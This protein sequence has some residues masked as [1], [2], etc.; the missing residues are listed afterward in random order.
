M[1]NRLISND[2]HKPTAA[3]TAV[4]RWKKFFAAGAV[5]VVIP[6][7]GGVSAPAFGDDMEYSATAGQSLALE[8]EA[9]NS[10]EETDKLLAGLD[11]QSLLNS[12]AV[13]EVENATSWKLDSGEYFIRVPLGGDV[14]KVSA[15]GVVVAPNG[16]VTSAA[17]VIA[18]QSS[19]DSGRIAAWNNGEKV[20]DR[21][22]FDHEVA[23]SE[24]AGFWGTLNK[25][26]SSAGVAG[27]VVAGLS[28]ACGAA[29]VGTA[30][31]GCVVCL[32]AASGIGAGTVSFCVNKALR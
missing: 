1:T 5:G 7:A 19:E 26:L 15:L 16:K 18:Q 4:T 6:F 31:A 9:E 27:W 3:K 20:A 30:G 32:T 22:V 29:C 14:D 2:H 8:L 10:S 28:V 24:K 17:E 11:V 12:E 13:P 21:I 25:C 23:S